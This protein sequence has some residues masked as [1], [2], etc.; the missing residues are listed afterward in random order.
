MNRST[1]PDGTVFIAVGAILGAFGTAISLL[2][3]GIVACLLH[4]SV[5]G[6]LPLLNTQRMTR[7]LLLFRPLPPRSTSTRIGNRR[8]HLLSVLPLDA[9]KEERTVAR[10]LR[11][12]PAKRT[13]SSLLPLLGGMGGS[14]NRDSRFLPLVS[15]LRPRR[16]PATATETQSACQTSDQVQEVILAAMGPSPPDSP[17]ARATPVPRIS[18]PALSISTGHRVAG[19]LVRIWTI[20]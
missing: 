11:L 14:S 8:L 10:F 1:L 12:L 20:F 5:D 13:Y 3:R 17:A 15:T 7:L 2:W 18:A 4:R 6:A 16:C 9:A 19:L